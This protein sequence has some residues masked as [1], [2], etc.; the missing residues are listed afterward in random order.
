M[1]FSLLAIGPFHSSSS[2]PWMKP[3]ASVTVTATATATALRRKG[4]RSPSFHLG[5]VVV[6]GV[7]TEALSASASAAL[8]CTALH[9]KAGRRLLRGIVY[10]QSNP[11][12]IRS[13]SHYLL[14]P[15]LI[16]DHP[17]RPCASSAFVVIHQP[18]IISV[19]Q[20]RQ[21][22]RLNPTDQ[23]PSSALSII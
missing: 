13:H 18:S 16:P 1:A 14:S 10:H 2:I 19:N 8:H 22:Q 17:L 5:V 12:S 3:G 20:S 9:S 15:V 6:F 21:T 23:L 7:A 11:Q 4:R